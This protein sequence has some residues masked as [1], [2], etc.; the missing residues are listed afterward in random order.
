MTQKIIA[1]TTRE[2]NYF[3]I[4]ATHKN[5]YN[6]TVV[7]TETIQ[8]MTPPTS[9]M[10]EDRHA[11]VRLKSQCSVLFFDGNTISGIVV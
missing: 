8:L 1:T 6:I 4:T 3:G 10:E 9:I 7:K 11:C 2:N 5:C